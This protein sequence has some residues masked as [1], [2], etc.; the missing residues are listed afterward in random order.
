VVASGGTALFTVENNVNA[1]HEIAA[2]LRP[3]ILMMGGHA[4]NLTGMTTNTAGGI[5]HNKSVHWLPFYSDIHQGSRCN[6]QAHLGFR[7]CWGYFL[8]CKSNKQLC[9]FCRVGA[10]YLI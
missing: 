5:S 4:G 1:R 6:I 2:L 10:F 9:S 8:R 3:V 7:V